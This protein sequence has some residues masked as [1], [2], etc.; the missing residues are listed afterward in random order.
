MLD[1]DEPGESEETVEVRAPRFPSSW[2]PERVEKLKALYTQGLSASL[3]AMHLGGVTRNAVIGKCDRLQL[4]YAK[5]REKIE[6]KQREETTGTRRQPVV[7]RKRA[8]SSSTGGVWRR[9]DSML[10]DANKACTDLPV[11][12]SPLATTINGL[13]HD[14]SQCRFPVTTPEGEAQLFCAADVV[15][16]MPYCARH[17]AVCYRKSRYHAD[18]FRQFGE[19]AL[20]VVENLEQQ[21]RDDNPK[22]A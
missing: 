5:K 10:L 21:R 6:R 19:I 13:L 22:A 17:C 12:S 7:R 16:G 4:G 8:A 18:T 9:I 15:E 14:R 11:D 2:T 20:S 1:M 3:I